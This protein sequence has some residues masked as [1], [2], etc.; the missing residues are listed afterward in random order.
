[1]TKIV[2][3]PFVGDQTSFSLPRVR[4]KTSLLQQIKCAVLT[5]QFR[6]AARLLQI[7]A[8]LTHN[9]CVLRSNFVVL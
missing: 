8:G 6:R 9:S 7:T 3:F 5:I 1:M 2:L 4:K